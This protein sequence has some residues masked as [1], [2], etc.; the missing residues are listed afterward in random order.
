[1]TEGSQVCEFSNLFNH[2]NDVIVY[3]YR[4]IKVKT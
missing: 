4:L 2:L 3:N 1:V